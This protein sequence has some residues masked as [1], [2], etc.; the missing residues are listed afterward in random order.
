M[1][2]TVGVA[3]GG[4]VAAAFLQAAAAIADSGPSATGADAFTLGDYTFDPFTTGDSGAVE[5]FDP[6]NPLS[7][8]PPLL[9]IGGGQ[10]TLANLGGIT[11]PQA[12]QNFEVYDPASGDNLGSINST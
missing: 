9:T 3:G 12:T 2:L 7:T 1:T 11:I 8:A 6:V 10:A 5:G 4:L